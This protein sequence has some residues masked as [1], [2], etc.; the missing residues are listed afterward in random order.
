VV[1]LSIRTIDLDKLRGTPVYEVIREYC[2]SNSVNVQDIDALENL[3]RVVERLK[4]CLESCDFR[5][6]GPLILLGNILIRIQSEKILLKNMDEESRQKFLSE[7]SKLYRMDIEKAINKAMMSLISKHKVKI[8]VDGQENVTCKSDIL[9]GSLNRRRDITSE[10]IRNVIQDDELY[11][12][13][14]EARVQGEII[15]KKSVSGSV[16]V[17][18]DMDR[19]QNE[20]RSKL[21]KGENIRMDELGMEYL[22]AFVA[23][24]F[25]AQRGEVEIFQADFNEPIFLVS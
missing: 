9:S 18:F 5:I 19:I 23:S 24:L 3:E 8:L 13:I 20:L 16:V 2:E 10:D 4:G 15:K 25:L 7:K 14:Y 11:K 6:A 17:D 22:D 1:E 12:C 21:K